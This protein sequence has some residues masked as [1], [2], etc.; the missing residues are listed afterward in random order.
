MVLLIPFISKS[1]DTINI[2]H[3]NYITT[4]SKSFKY[5]L[6]VEWWETKAKV[7]CKDPLPRTD[8][9]RPDPLLPK[10][11]SLDDDYKN[12]GYDRGHMCPAA[13]NTC[14]PQQVLDECFYYSNMS[15]QLHNLNAGLWKN[16]EVET[17]KISLIKDS[18][19][20]WAGNLG[21]VKKIGPDNISV[22]E[23]CWKVI[24]IVKDKQYKCYL[25]Y[26]KN[27]SEKD[28]NKFETTLDNIKK[29]TGFK[30]N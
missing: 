14:L 1:Q 2:S 3:T 19:H 11:T 29:L 17:R 8:K 28:I 30:F 20:V 25:F 6:K 4:F 21:S 24:Y 22:P 10:E 16:L 23:K 5:P 15:P 26:N 12:S 7:A 13:S 18:I 27:S 9:F